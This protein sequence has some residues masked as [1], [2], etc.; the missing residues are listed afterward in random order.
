M[1]ESDKIKQQ[2]GC[3]L[4]ELMAI[5]YQRYLDA[6]GNPRRKPSGLKE[7]DYLTDAE[8]QEALALARAIFDDN[9]I[10]HY[11]Q[12]KYQNSPQAMKTKS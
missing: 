8:R 3:R 6:G 9:Y 4:D 7:N 5:A 11:L 10:N 2:Q 1:K 12:K